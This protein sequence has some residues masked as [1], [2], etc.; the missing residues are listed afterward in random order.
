MT[1]YLH[2][3]GSDDHVPSP[4]R[5]LGAYADFASALAERDQDVIRQ[6][7]AAGGQPVVITHLIVGPG[8]RGPA[9]V[10]PVT[11]SVGQR[12]RVGDLSVLLADTAHWLATIHTTNTAD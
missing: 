3:A 1:Y 5:P 2:Q 6:L 7:D 4:G 8:L 11:S 10:H 12:G 9:T